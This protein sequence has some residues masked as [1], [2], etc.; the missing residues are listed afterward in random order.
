[1]WDMAVGTSLPGAA[2]LIG[3]GHWTTSVEIDREV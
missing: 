3:K 2:T 1:M